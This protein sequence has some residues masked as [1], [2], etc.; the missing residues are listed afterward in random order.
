MESWN[1]KDDGGK[2]GAPG[3]SSIKKRKIVTIKH[4]LQS[5]VFN[6]PEGKNYWP[7]C[8]SYV[9]KLK[10]IKDDMIPVKDKLHRQTQIGVM[11]YDQMTH[12]KI[13]IGAIED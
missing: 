8:D 3:S 4:R 9:P 5:Q 12:R 11:N 1:Q 6:S 13:D 7:Y 10:L 2:T